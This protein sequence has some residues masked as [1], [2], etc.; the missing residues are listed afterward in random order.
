MYTISE[1]TSP[2]DREKRY[3]D[4]PSRKVTKVLSTP[5]RTRWR[6]GIIA[7]SINTQRFLSVRP[8]YST[9]FAT[10][11]KGMFRASHLYDLVQE[12]TSQEEELLRDALSSPSR[13]QKQYY[14]I[15]NGADR[16]G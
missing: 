12:L 6:Y 11:L 3:L 8:R 4:L 13:L 5:H 14:N 10:L 9:G 1:W 2:S 16:E 7:Y 15:I